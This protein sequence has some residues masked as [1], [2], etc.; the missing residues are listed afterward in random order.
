MDE[1]GRVGC[2]TPIF[3]NLEKGFSLEENWEKKSKYILHSNPRKN[4]FCGRD[5]KLIQGKVQIFWS[6][7]EQL[8]NTKI[9]FF[10]Q[11]LYCK[12]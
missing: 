10:W 5:N 8:I 4:H 7:E 12:L 11:V 2:I 9:I 6:Y 3:T 1:R